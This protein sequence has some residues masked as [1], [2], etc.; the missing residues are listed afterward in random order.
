MD[1][2][3]ELSALLNSADVPATVAT[4]ARI[5]LWHAEQ[6]PKKDIAVLASVSRPTVDLWIDRYERE[7]LGGLLDRPRG[8][9]PL[10]SAADYADRISERCEGYVSLLRAHE[11][12]QSGTIGVCTR[13]AIHGRAS[14][15][16]RAPNCQV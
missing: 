2:R 12:N 4:R 5:V 13:C 1:E 15:N 8:P 7:G 10:S 14:E 16:A 6:R 3:T 9:S 11:T